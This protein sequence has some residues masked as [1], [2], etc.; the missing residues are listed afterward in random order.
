MA[1]AVL[2]VLDRRGTKTVRKMGSVH[3]TRG[4]QWRDIYAHLLSPDKTI[5]KKNE[6]ASRETRHHALVRSL[7]PQQP[8]IKNSI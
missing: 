7:Q 8:L 6:K 4:P 3:W 2:R 5:L 1:T